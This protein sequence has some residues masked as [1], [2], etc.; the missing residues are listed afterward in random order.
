MARSALHRRGTWAGVTAAVFA[1]ALLLRI[2]RV[3]S[4]PAQAIVALAAVALAA[5]AAW[6]L[7]LVAALRRG[8][9][10]EGFDA[11]RALACRAGEADA[12]R[13]A[14]TRRGAAGGAGHVRRAA[15]AAPIVLS[16]ALGAV[17]ISGILNAAY[18]LEGTWVQF[19]DS[20][21]DLDLRAT[22]RELDVGLLA[23]PADLKYGVVVGEVR[24][25]EPARLADVSVVQ[26][27]GVAAWTGVLPAGGATALHG[28]QLYQW[29][30]GPAVH[31]TV[32]HRERGKLFDQPVPLWPAARPGS[33][34]ETIVGDGMALD[35]AVSRWPWRDGEEG[36]A[37]AK[38]RAGDRVLLDTALRPREVFA[39]AD[40]YAVIAW[41]L[42][43]YVGLGVVHRTFRRL[44]VVAL[45]AA[46]AAV[47]AW[48]VLRPR[49][50]CYV[51]EPDGG[52][53]VSPASAWAALRRGGRA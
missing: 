5:D 41:E 44:T 48:A 28:L 18:H 37:R 1:A 24:P 49:P 31:V 14:A 27:G 35:L 52:V 45:A 10:E 22:Y 47:A 53:R 36:E 4:P 38:L 2:A 13:R 40:G 23:N 32:V 21:R 51:E 3:A 12:V 16:L 33:Y 17:L 8:P 6:L 7:S 43:P 9:S 20:G 50:F 26:P 30:Y 15:L 19:A 46:L 11:A 25:A 34:G 29:S 42:R 39:A